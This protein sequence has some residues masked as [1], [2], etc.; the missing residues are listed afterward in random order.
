MKKVTET[1]LKVGLFVG[2][3]IAMA[4]AAILFLGGTRTIFSRQ[5][6]YPMPF[7]LWTGLS[8]AQRWFWAESRLAPWIT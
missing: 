7:L 3:G 5:V 8:P 4:G 2:L 6:A 1:E